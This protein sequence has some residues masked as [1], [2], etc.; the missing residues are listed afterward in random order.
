MNAEQQRIQKALEAGKTIY[1]TGG[2]KLKGVQ[3]KAEKIETPNPPPAGNEE[4]DKPEG[5]PRRSRS[6]SSS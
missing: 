3:E 6:R 4:D 2:K 5:S 1:L